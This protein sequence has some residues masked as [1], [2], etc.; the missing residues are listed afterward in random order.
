M[1]KRAIMTIDCY[2]Q[3]KGKGESGNGIDH[4]EQVCGGKRLHNKR[5]EQWN[6]D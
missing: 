5:N 1:K 3:M 2:R 4:R 6:N